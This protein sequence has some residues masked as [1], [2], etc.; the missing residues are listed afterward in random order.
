MIVVVI[1]RVV[2]IVV[3]GVVVVVVIVVVVAEVILLLIII[4]VVVVVI[5]VVIVVEIAV[6]IVLEVILVLVFVVVIV[7]IVEVA[8]IISTYSSILCLFFVIFQWQSNSLGWRIVYLIYRILVAMFWFVILILSG[9]LDLGWYTPNVDG[10][11]WF[12]YLTNWGLFIL[13]IDA[14][15]QAFTCMYRIVKNERWHRFG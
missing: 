10:L 8:A 12:V 2:V 11:L 6:E 15:L 4:V 1:T 9:V 14:N 3:V 5:E 7:V 13:T